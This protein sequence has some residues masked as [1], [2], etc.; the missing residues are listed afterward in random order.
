MGNRKVFE[1]FIKQR[2]VIEAG[3]VLG[4]EMDLNTLLGLIAAEATKVVDADC[5]SIWIVDKKK[6]VLW[7]PVATGIARRLEVPIGTGLVGAVAQTKETINIPDA[8]QDERF[9][10]SSDQST[11]YHTRQ[12][13]SVPMKNMRGDVT[14]VAQVLNQAQDSPF[15]K[16]DADL[17][18]SLAGHAAIV[19]EN[20]QLYDE[21]ADSYRQTLLAMTFLL[22][23]RDQETENHSVR[24][25]QFALRIAEEMGMT[26]SDPR[27][28]RNAA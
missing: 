4:S 23:L 19:V 25:V 7:T 10:P 17:L 26:N 13:L 5:S 1:A 22:E 11:G 27:I 8:Y 14:G 21:I 28:R 3:R 24:V 18:T 20:A 6:N 2:M 16:L 12:I 15:T 9:D